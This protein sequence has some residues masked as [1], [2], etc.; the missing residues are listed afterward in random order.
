MMFSGKFQ[1]LELFLTQ[2]HHATILYYLV[3]YFQ[4][5]T[6]HAKGILYANIS[7]LGI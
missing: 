4:Q 1:G 3:I 5:D 7:P 6:V 2:P